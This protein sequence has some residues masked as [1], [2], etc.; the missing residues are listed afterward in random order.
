MQLATT[1][2]Q[3][4]PMSH[5]KTGP[6]AAYWLLALAIVLL[7][8]QW[9]LLPLNLALADLALLTLILLTLAQAAAGR[10]AV[11]LPLLG[12]MLLILIVSAISTAVG[13]GR[14]ESAMV[15]VQEIYIFVWFL[16]LTSQ[17]RTLTPQ[18]QD[19]LLKIWAIIACI[20]SVTTVLGMLKIGPAMFYTK[21]TQDAIVTDE[22]TRAVGLHANSNAAAVYLS[23]SFFAALAANW[24]RRVRWPTA[25]WIYVGIFAT[26]SN[27]ALLSTALGLGV[28][29][30][31]YSFH[32]NRD[33]TKLWG[34]LT[35]LG[36]GFAF[37]LLLATAF[38]PVSGFAGVDDSNHF[39]FYTI[40]RFSHSLE[41]RLAIIDWSWRIYKTHPLGV[42]PNGFSTLQGSL[43]NDYIAFWFER[44]LLGLVGW[45]WLVLAAVWAPFRA[46]ARIP[47]TE[48]RRCW[49]IIAL[50]SGFLACAVNAFSHEIS[51]MRQ[52]W[53]LI[54]FVFA[55]SD[56][57]LSGDANG[58]QSRTYHQ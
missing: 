3:T 1:A 36:V 26:G 25:A 21:P 56:R 2:K 16:A 38:L 32:S 47:L 6:P 41:S 12:P 57:R 55:M 13:F 30:F 58:H 15:I 51:H 35:T 11:I 9:L 17:L 40:G 39:L 34:S 54:V 33:K 49:T 48:K 53:M 23:V 8:L 24:P 27:G 14:F 52:L 5:I 50:G 45:V 42:G 20:E 7:P 37:V 19:R 29:I 22:V 43:H 28:L 44:G 4:T 18:E 46:A 10:R 31:A